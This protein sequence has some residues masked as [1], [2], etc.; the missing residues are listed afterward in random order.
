MT[1]L[2][3]GLEAL[4]GSDGMNIGS[5]E[6][7]LLPIDTVMPNPYQPR[8]H[9]DEIAL[10]ELALSIQDKGILQPLVVRRVQD[11]FQLVAGERR[12]R[13]AKLAQFKETKRGKKKKK[14]KK[15]K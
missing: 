1:R 3:K 12:L 10:Q 5:E 4:L 14:K 9:F 6:F 7:I 11:Q 2:G 15:H 13:A 8:R